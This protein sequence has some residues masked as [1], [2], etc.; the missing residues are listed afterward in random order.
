MY[1][2]LEICWT[3]SVFF[4]LLLGVKNEHGYFVN[5]KRHSKRLHLCNGYYS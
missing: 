1:I 2:I 3:F 4:F 5:L